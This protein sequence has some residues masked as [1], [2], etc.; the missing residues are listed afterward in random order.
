MDKQKIQRHVKIPISDIMDSLTQRVAN[1]YG[2]E[3]K[4]VKCITKIE[5]ITFEIP[6]LNDEICNEVMPPIMGD[7]DEVIDGCG[8]TAGACMCGL[9]KGHGKHHICVNCG[10][11][12]DT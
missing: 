2:V 4:D 7:H 9:P 3:Q 11:E 5:Y 8:S 1:H 6:G 12:W 10:E